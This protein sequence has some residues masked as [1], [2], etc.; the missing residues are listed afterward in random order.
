MSLARTTPKKPAKKA[1]ARKAAF[2]V[3]PRWPTPG[4]AEFRKLPPE[5]QAWVTHANGWY[6]RS[7]S[8]G[9]PSCMEDFEETET[10][11]ANRVY[12]YPFLVRYFR[13]NP[14]LFNFA[15]HYLTGETMK[16]S[17]IPGLHKAWKEWFKAR[18]QTRPPRSPRRAYLP[19]NH[20]AHFMAAVTSTTSKE[21]FDQS[22]T[23]VSP[24][25]VLLQISSTAPT[26]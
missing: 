8:A 4:S 7:S 2:K 19:L 24:K 21:H 9:D 17:S 10:V 26:R 3:P 20:H 25:L 14:R 12:Y 11:E 16:A 13:L 1:P 5:D 6:L 15:L 23:L 22:T 18:Q